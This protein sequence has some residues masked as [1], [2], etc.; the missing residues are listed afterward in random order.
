MFFCRK[1]DATGDH[2]AK[3]L[4]Q[5]QKEKCFSYMWNLNFIILHVSMHTYIIYLHVCVAK[6]E[7]R[8]FGRRNGRKWREREGQ[9]TIGNEHMEKLCV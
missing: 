5:A 2:Q 7:K 8:L 6:V 3:Q 4:S 9:K 1:M